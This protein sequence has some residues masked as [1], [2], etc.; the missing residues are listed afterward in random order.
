ME[1]IDTEALA[2]MRERS[3]PG[4]KW[5][6]YENKDMSHRDLGRL[7]FIHVGDACT[8]KEAPAKCPDTAVGLGWRYLLVG[9]VN[10]EDGTIEALP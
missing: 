10:L 2:Q 5:A 8:F 6:A 1:A 3:R 9:T 7:Q 4:T